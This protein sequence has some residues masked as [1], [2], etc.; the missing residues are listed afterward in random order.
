MNI[1]AIHSTTPPMSLTRVDPTLRLGSRFEGL[2]EVGCGS[3]GAVYKAWDRDTGRYVALKVLHAEATHER[4]A[5]E[6]RVLASI[7]HE[8]CVRYVGHGVTNGKHW[9]AMEWL[10]GE[11]LATRLERGALSTDET[12]A[13]AKNLADVLAWGHDRGLLHRDL[14]PSNLLLPGGSIERVKLLDFGLA[15][16]NNQ[17]DAADTVTGACMGTLDY[18]PPEQV[19]DAKRADSRA[20]IYSLGAV[21]FHCLAG[22]PPFTSRTTTEALA[23]ILS[24]E[25][26]RVSTF[27]PEA[28]AALVEL[29][30]KMLA[31]DREKRPRDGA[32]V[33]GTLA[34][35][36]PDAGS[37]SV[38]MIRVA[39]NF[40]EPTGVSTV[41]T[42]GVAALPV[43]DAPTPRTRS[44]TLVIPWTALEGRSPV[45]K[46]A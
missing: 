2:K 9:L 32:A 36:S 26:P 23:N 24:K 22:R 12:L 41:R 29:V 43:P 10:E 38:T 39:V 46:E 16:I 3:M 35:I 42:P 44:G 30:T 45:P 7:R 13:L 5:R 20:D 18:M 40:D 4:F 25:S 34:R 11:D 15:R 1:A 37:E 27:R 8:H 28:P 21:L 33:R 31:K 17:S 19:T 6:S 14:K